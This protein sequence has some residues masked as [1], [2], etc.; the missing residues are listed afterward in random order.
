[1]NSRKKEWMNAKNNLQQ[2]K[3][4]AS[5]DVT[6]NLCDELKVYAANKKTT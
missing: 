2:L 5:A 1:M 3:E 4:G 6:W